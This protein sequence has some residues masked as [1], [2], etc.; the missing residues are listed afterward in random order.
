VASGPYSSLVNVTCPLLAGLL[1]LWL[2]G[3]L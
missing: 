1:A 2:L 3:L